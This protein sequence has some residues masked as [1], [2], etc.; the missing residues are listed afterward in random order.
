[1]DILKFGL[2]SSGILKRARRGTDLELT[3]DRRELSSEI[4][5]PP[6]LGTWVPAAVNA[7]A[8]GSPGAVL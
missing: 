6:A 1:M 5:S 7:D 3:D 4:P 2:N 8:S